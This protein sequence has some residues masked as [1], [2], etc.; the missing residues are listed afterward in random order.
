[1][2]R[3]VTLANK[4][5]NQLAVIEDEL[6]MLIDNPDDA[7]LSPDREHHVTAALNHIAMAIQELGQLK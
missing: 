1:M 3:A 5:V 6:R 4:K 2:T 7:G